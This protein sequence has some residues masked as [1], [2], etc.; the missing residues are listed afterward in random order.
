MGHDAHDELLSIAQVAKMY[1]VS[2]E[3]VRRWTR[4]GVIS[5]VMV[6]PFKLKRIPKEEAA[7][8]FRSVEGAR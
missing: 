6:G 8:H 3:T 4:K 7:R 5:Y 2:D 1:G